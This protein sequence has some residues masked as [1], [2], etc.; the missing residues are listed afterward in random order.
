MTRKE[1]IEQA[2]SFSNMISNDFIRG[3]E[4]ADEN[5]SEDH[6]AAY[7]GKKGWPLSSQGIPTY[8]QANKMMLEY[9]EYKKI[10]WIEKACWFIKNHHH[11]FS[12]WNTEE[13]ELEFSTQKFIEDFR[14]AMEQ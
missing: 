8:E 11:E 12:F 1:E 2:A 7:L 6:I 3:T 13:H 4:W 10:Q 14:K 5:P 9:F